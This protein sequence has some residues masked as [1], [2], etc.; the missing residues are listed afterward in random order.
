MRFILTKLK[1]L[2]PLP[3][4][5]L[6]FFQIIFIFQGKRKNWC[7]CGYGHGGLRLEKHFRKFI[8]N[9]SQC[10]INYSC[11]AG[12]IGRSYQELMAGRG[13]RVSPYFVPRILP[14]LAPGYIR[15]PLASY[16]LA[17]EQLA[18][19]LVRLQQSRLF[20]LAVGVVQL[21]SY[22]LVVEQLAFLLFRLQQSR[23]FSLAVGLHNLISISGDVSHHF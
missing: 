20:S 18:F 8:I 22:W 14:N 7:C 11:V 16:W 15:Y 5:C 19:L 6:V 3:N 23:L 10:L 21:D 12:Y 13:K 1:N 9:Q 17:V 4:S 2:I